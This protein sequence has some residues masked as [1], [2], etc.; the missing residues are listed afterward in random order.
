M[1]TVRHQQIL[2]LLKEKGHV[3]AGVLRKR[4]GVTAMTVWR[5]LGMLEELGLL[6]RVRGGAVAVC[7]GAAENPF[8]EKSAAE[9]AVKRRIAACAAA[10]FLHE[11][12]TVILEGGTTVAAAVDFLPEKRISIFTN[13]LPVA[14]RVRAMRPDLPIR[15]T[16]GWVSPVSGNLTGPEAVREIGKL[17][18]SVCFLSATGFNAKLGPTDPNPMEIEVKRAWAAV[19]RKTILLLDHSKFGKRSLAVTIHPRNL[20]ALVTDAAPP[21]EVARLLARWKIPV[22]VAPE[23]M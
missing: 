22:H 11:G 14:L 12:D 15:V 9:R 8:E 17:S 3:S 2:A 7:P 1:H 5:D 10:R 18:A 19:A 16:G 20:S 21:G 4:L 6:R 13:S 23:G